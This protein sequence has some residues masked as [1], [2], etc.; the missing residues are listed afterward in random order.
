MND[1]KPSET[2]PS[3]SQQLP[4]QSPDTAEQIALRLEAE[5][6][7]RG[8]ADALK[9]MT[10][11]GDCFVLVLVSGGKGGSTSYASNAK[12]EQAVRV[13]SELLDHWVG[14]DDMGLEPSTKT[15]AFLRENVAPLHRKATLAQLV[16]GL[17]NGAAGAALAFDK[18]E[19]RETVVQAMTAATHA[20]ALYQSFNEYQRHRKRGAC[21][22]KPGAE[23]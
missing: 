3:Q 22:S 8:M 5:K 15:A 23:S 18:G 14:A 9:A 4:D 1:E 11:P 19:T 10:A 13:L 21:P 17:V 20:L 16:G 12:R 7:M 2:P 6:R